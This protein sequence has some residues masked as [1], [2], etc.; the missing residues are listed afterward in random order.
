M[1][2][3]FDDPYCYPGTTVL[4]NKL[5]LSDADRLAGFEQEMTDLRAAEPMPIGPLDVTLFKKTHR[6]LFQDVYSWAGEFRTVRISKDASSFCFPE[7]IEG[8][9]RGLFAWLKSAGSL[10]GRNKADFAAGAAH[11]LT[12]INVI[13]PF[14]EGNGRTQRA[15]LALLAT[16]AGHPLDLTRLAPDAFLKAM[17]AGFWGDEKPLAAQIESLIARP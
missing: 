13:H 5:G 6:H 14:R 11:L 15:F 12:E 17:I 2:E 16:K 4:I 7:Y 8:Q 9:M 3:N 10:R 1:Y